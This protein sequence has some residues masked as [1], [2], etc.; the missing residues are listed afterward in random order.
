MVQKF[1]AIAGEYGIT[2]RLCTCKNRSMKSFTGF[3]SDTRALAAA[4]KVTE[5]TYYMEGTTDDQR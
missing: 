2:V 5:D 3:C 1:Q 4:D